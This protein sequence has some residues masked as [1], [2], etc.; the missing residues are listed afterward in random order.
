MVIMVGIEIMGPMEL[1]DI[2]NSVNNFNYFNFGSKVDI[3]DIIINFKIN[4]A[5]FKGTVSFIGFKANINF[6]DFKEDIIS[7]FMEFIPKESMEDNLKMF[8]Q[9]V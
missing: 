4:F 3:E 8:L 9:Q 1:Y 6:I 2:N 7:Y 5:N